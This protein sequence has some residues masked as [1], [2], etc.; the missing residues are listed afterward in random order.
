[1]KRFNWFAGIVMAGVTLAS[2][3]TTESDYDPNP[4]PQ[5]SPLAW[6]LVIHGGAGV[7]RRDSM[8]AETEAAYMSALDGVLSTGETMLADGT[9][10]I[11]VVETIIRS[12]EDDPLFN[13]GRGAVMT[14]VGT[15][16][17]DAS[18]MRGD[19]L[20]AGAVAGLSNVKHPI[21]AA[22]KAMEQSPHV[23][24]AGD[25][26][27]QFAAQQALE[28]VDPSWFYTN[29]RWESLLKALERRGVAAPENLYGP[30]PQTN[31]VES[32]E[33]EDLSDLAFPDDRKY[34]TVGVV[35]M[36]QDG[37]IVAG[38]STGGTTAKRWGR[39]GDSPV[40]GAGTYAKNDVC[41]VSATGT[42]E[43][44]IRLSIAYAICSRVELLG[45]TAQ[46]AADYIIHTSLTDLGG[47]GGVIVLGPDG[48][49]AWSFNTEG[50][51]RAKAS[52]DGKKL[53]E[54]FGDQHR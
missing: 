25:G 14:E 48:T 53:I 24:L 19:T 43:Y 20:D 40:I 46:E 8:S 35:A 34:G 41:G 38:T 18:I 28:I 23:M 30:K 15:F 16:S 4:G 12:L 21:S 17:L 51:Y 26:A 27:D 50:M 9:P 5:P 29:R 31:P 52:S 54:I 32:I 45:E 13:A 39:V 11:D 10:A 2:C 1:M 6:S 49:P 44:F 7:I 36:D 33:R 22:R 42:G 37:N 3:A 47:D